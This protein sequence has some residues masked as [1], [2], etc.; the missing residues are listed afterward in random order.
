[1]EVAKKGAK[2]TRGKARCEAKPQ[3]RVD[4]IALTSHSGDL[5]TADYKI[6]ERGHRVEM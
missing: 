1:M 2:T 4:G 6:S 5:I 3:K